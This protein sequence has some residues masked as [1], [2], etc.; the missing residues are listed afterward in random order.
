MRIRSFQKFTCVLLAVLIL[1][2]TPACDYLDALHLRRAEAASVAVGVTAV[3]LLKVT[4]AAFGVVI[5]TAA[6]SKAVD[7]FDRWLH[8][9]GRAESVALWNQAQANAQ[10]VALNE[11]FVGDVRRWLEDRFSTLDSGEVSTA[12]VGTGGI[13]TNG[14]PVADPLLEA[15]FMDRLPLWVDDQPYLYFFRNG[16]DDSNN[17]YFLQVTDLVEADAFYCISA[18]SRTYLCPVVDGHLDIGSDYSYKYSSCLC[19][20]KSDLSLDISW[21]SGWI[22]NQFRVSVPFDGVPTFCA[23]CPVIVTDLTSVGNGA[24]LS[25]VLAHATAT[26]GLDASVPLGTSFGSF[27]DSNLAK[28]CTLQLTSA[29]ISKIQQAVDQAVSDNTST[30]EDG[31]LVYTPDISQAII[32]AYNQGLTDAGTVV[33]PID[34]DDPDIPVVPDTG[35]IL[36]FLAGLKDS[37]KDWITSIPDAVAAVGDAVT[38]ALE[39]GWT[40]LWEYLTAIKDSL[41]GILTGVTDIPDVIGGLFTDLHGWILDIPAAVVPG[42]DEITVPIV[43]AIKDTFTVDA[44]AVQE[45]VEAERAE[46]WNFPFL[47]QAKELYD[48]FSFP[49]EVTYPK[50]KIETPAILR[51]YY[52]QP[53]IVLLDFEDYKDYCLWARLLFRASIWLWLIWHVVDLATPKLRIS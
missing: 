37:L 39:S 6:A 19:S 16:Y 12:T 30:G 3:S 1:W 23:S 8:Q 53:E 47:V 7:A 42:A 36:D 20:L 34:P 43:D 49:A 52:P 26:Y 40:T 21:N 31:T 46:L 10:A 11:S 51:A 45:A 44:D 28:L 14:V 48:G 4:A 9:E 35:G 17:V 24:L 18:G 29:G 33:D 13:I 22:R 2:M 27:A 32:D 15:A 38:D 5:A 41:A 25:N 50:I